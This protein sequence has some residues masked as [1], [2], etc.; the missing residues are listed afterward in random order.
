M[1]QP[2]PARRLLPLIAGLLSAAV[3]VSWPVHADAASPGAPDRGQAAPAASRPGLPPAVGNL[4]G[5]A[6]ISAANCMAVGGSSGPAEGHALAERWNGSRWTLV[7]TPSP[8]NEDLSAVACP[9]ASLCQA[10]GSV[11]AEKW[12]GATWSLEKMPTNVL[13]P[14][15]SSV[16]CPAVS[17]CV[18]V[19]G[20]SNGKT[21]VTLAETWNGSTWTVHNPVN[22]AGAL[23]VSLS[24]V[25]CVSSTSCIA[26][27]TYEV[28][29][30]TFAALAESWN[31]HSWTRLP[32]APLASSSTGL[33]GISCASATNC[34]AVG[35]ADPGTLAE[36]WNGSAWTVLPAPP[37]GPTAISCTSAAGCMAIGG[38]NTES[39]NGSAWT[40][41]AVP[42]LSINLSGVSCSSATNCMAVGVLFGAGNFAMSWNGSAWRPRRVNQFG[43]LAGVSCPAAV[44]CM[45]AGRFL[46]RADLHLALAASWNGSTWRRRS[47]PTVARESQLADVSCASVTNC[48]AVGISKD[49]TGFFTLAE[50]WNGVTWRVT[51]TPKLS[52]QSPLNA[53]SCAGSR[54]MA[55]SR[56]MFSELWN[57]STWHVIKI[58]EPSPSAGLLTDVS[59]ASAID[60]MATGSFF[61]DPH[62]NPISLSELWNGTKWRRLHPP[63]GGLNTVSCTS[64]SFCM[65]LGKDTAAIWNGRRWRTQKLP[66]SF[67]FGP[68]ITAV[69]C[70]RASA[71]MAV[72]NYLASGPQGIRGFNVAEFWN[73]TRWR[74]LATPGRGGGLADV[75]CTRPARC[76]AV[77]LVQASQVGTRTVAMR[78]NGTRWHLLATPNP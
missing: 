55:I 71:C 37:G 14:S 30:N 33:S 40:P 21:A 50:A 1:T 25:S 19:G 3:T 54:C 38:K 48:V 69:S 60:C 66:G 47:T 4:N 32:L 64:A 61:P 68:G 46:T 2:N 59:C 43:E 8:S 49:R 11:G 52:Q 6:C 31:G 57:G 73:G 9:S 12:N 75:S 18:A 15:L 65:A 78:W 16:S 56:F 24:S 67:G 44:G 26:V 34:V 77:G 53:V 72:G 23:Q 62:G 17:D 45:A 20:R 35:F 13:A 29:N 76:M 58:P 27:G 41:L 51:P 70:S 42:P 10:V 36:S 74:R 63:G 7:A 5:V 39:W 22:P 28:S